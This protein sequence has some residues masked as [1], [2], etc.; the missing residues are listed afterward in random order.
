[1]ADPKSITIFYSWQSDSD[2]DCNLKAIRNA[3][4]LASV[5]IESDIENVTLVPDEAT[6]DTAGSPDIPAT[7]FQK[8]SNSDIFICDITT[9]N[10]EFKDVPRKTSNPNVLIELGYAVAILGWERIIMLFNKSF[11]QFPLDLPFDIDRRRI[12]DY[13][14]SSKDDNNGKGQLKGLLKIAVKTIIEKNP[15]KPNEI[16]NLSPE[17]KRRRLDIMNLTKILSTIHIPSLDLFLQDA[18]GAVHDRIFHFWESFNGIKNSGLF[19]LY[20]PSAK[21]LIEKVHQYWGESLSFGHC[22][23]NAADYHLYIWG[24]PPH[25]PTTKQDEEDL[26]KVSIAVNELR[27]VSKELFQFIRDNYM[28]IDL[29]ETS[30]NAIEEYIAFHEEMTTELKK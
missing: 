14:V 27:K 17:E 2:Q 23:R 4:R 19:H 10:H 13:S 15:L 20:D 26:E 11:G 7:I 16:Q 24:S 1:M 30:K 9:I 29:N 5:D 12:S 21:Q 3:L 6:R 22:Y 25:I 18:P 28:E 8:I